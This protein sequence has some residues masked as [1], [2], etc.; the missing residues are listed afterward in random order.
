MTTKLVTFDG[1]GVRGV[2]SAVALSL[3]ESLSGPLRER[4]DRLAGTSV[5]SILACGVSS[6]L[7]GAECVDLAGTL[8]SR[9]FPGRWARWRNR[10]G[11][12]FSDGPSAPW[13][14]ARDLEAALRD[15]F[16]GDLRLGDLPIPVDVPAYDVLANEMHLFSSDREPDA[17]IPLWEACK[18]SA[19]APTYFSAH[20]TRA[21]GRRLL[22]VDGGI[23]VNNPA[24]VS[25]QRAVERGADLA[26]IRCVS[27]GTGVVKTPP[28]DPGGGRGLLQWAAG[29][30]STLMDATSDVH[31]H[32]SR[33]L[34]P[35]GALVRL[36]AEI[37]AERVAL[38]DASSENL[39]W[40]RRAARRRF[41]GSA[42][43]A[44]AARALR[45]VG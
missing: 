7:S 17:E 23:G 26:E 1:G 24:A 44:A 36:Q 5:G 21:T 16:P 6:G 28:E 2:I 29:I 35:P 42:A 27:L 33:G 41:S 19:S 31:L 18:A 38:D 9:V 8:A 14:D 10:A 22:L 39:R 20:E 3:V 45:E 25:V 32:L 34:L 4:V 43:V 30:A 12:L 15:V 13:Y 11:R 40:L 37:P